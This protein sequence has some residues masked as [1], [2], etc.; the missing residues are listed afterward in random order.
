[1]NLLVR[2]PPQ[3]GLYSALF[4]PLI[5][6]FF[7]HS[8]VK[9]KYFDFVDL[10]LFLLKQLSVGPESVISILA[11]SSIA[12]I[13]NN[14]NGSLPDINLVANYAA[15]LSF[16]IGIITLALGLVRFGFLDNVLSK[17][18]LR[19]FITAVGIIITIDQLD[20]FLGLDPN[21]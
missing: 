19:A 18:L 3:N 1:M 15:S 20:V 14:G 17:P 11:G 9:K 4:P 7:G 2:A 10:H 5:Y 13:I 8:R 6:F 21:V 12:T 16:I